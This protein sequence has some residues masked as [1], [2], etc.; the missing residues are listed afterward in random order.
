MS[1]NLRNYTKASIT[2][3]ADM[4]RNMNLMG[5]A[6]EVP[7][8]ADAMTRFLGLIGRNPVG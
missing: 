3:N 6:V 5:E 4:M 8:D 7:S 1:E 2:P